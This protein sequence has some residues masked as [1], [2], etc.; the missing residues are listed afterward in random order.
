MEYAKIMNKIFPQYE[1]VLDHLAFLRYFDENP[2]YYLENVV[3]RAIH[4]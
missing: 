1:Q 2:E 3:K 4:R